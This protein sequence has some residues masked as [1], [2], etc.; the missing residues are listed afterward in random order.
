MVAVA[1][2]FLAPLK[3]AL[4]IRV[5]PRALSEGTSHSTTLIL[6]LGAVAPRT[7]AGGIIPSIPVYG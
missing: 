3:S 4:S 1:A 2:T 7:F 6:G 5:L